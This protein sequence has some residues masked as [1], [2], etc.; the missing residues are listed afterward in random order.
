MF[1]IV[2]KEI[3]VWGIP[4]LLKPV[5]TT[6]EEEARAEMRLYPNGTLLQEVR[7]VEADPAKPEPN[8]GLHESEGRAVPFDPERDLHAGK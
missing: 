4:G 6:N 7:V 5:W 1:F 3:P 8:W 2:L